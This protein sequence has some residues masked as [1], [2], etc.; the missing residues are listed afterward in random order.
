M[1]IVEKGKSEYQVLSLGAG[2]QSSTLALMAE[3]GLI[4]PMP[5]FAV[6]ADTQ[7]E[8]D[9]VYK[10]LEFLKPKLSFPVVTVSKGNL[11][12][13]SMVV[14]TSRSGRKRL[15]LGIPLFTQFKA[16]TIMLSRQCTKHYKVMTVARAIRE[17][18]EFRTA[19]K[20]LRIIQWIGISR[21]E[22][23]R[24]KSSRIKWIEN[25][26]PL[27]DML[28]DRKECLEWL[29]SQGYPEPPKSACYFCPY[30]SNHK[31]QKMKT[32]DPD[33][34]RKAVEWETAIN[35][36][37]LETDFLKSPVRIHPSLQPLD[38][39]EFVDL[40]Q[41]TMFTGNNFGNE[42]EGMCGV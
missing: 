15:D 37:R 5:D 6:F 40:R 12:V 18:L 7:N 27:I 22:A 10:W 30:N 31:W 39:V 23:H 9:A 16:R 21:D 20:N 38:Q 26:Y 36:K 35:E 32:E 2:V 41:M 3:H 11:G 24:M 8:P 25:R 17:L 28:M 14:K 42:C 13:D 33:S 1:N 34:F 4:K 19:P 29:A